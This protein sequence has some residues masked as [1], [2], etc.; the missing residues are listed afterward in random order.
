MDLNNQPKKDLII[1]EI[2]IMRESTH[3]NI[4]NFNDSYLVKEELWVVMEFMEGGSLTDVID[5]NHMSEPQIAAVTREVCLRPPFF[6]LLPPR[7]FS[8]LL[9]VI[10]GLAHLHSKN[11]I[12]RDIKSDNILLDLQGLVKLSTVNTFPLFVTD[13]FFFFFHSC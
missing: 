7:L 10:A 3:P 11:I 2:I 13:S 4:V 1:N 6:F 12:H 5:N 8:F 9:Q